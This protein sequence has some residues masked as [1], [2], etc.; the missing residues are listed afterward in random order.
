MTSTSNTVSSWSAW[1]ENRK[2]CFHGLMLSIVKSFSIP[3]KYCVLFLERFTFCKKY[4]HNWA[5][6]MDRNFIEQYSIVQ[7][8]S[9][10]VPYPSSLFKKKNKFSNFN[11]LNC[12]N[13]DKKYKSRFETMKILSEIKSLTKI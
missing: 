4:S 10:R 3:N 12:R 8:T 1:N 11:F 13:S 2:M 7:F 9:W 5:I 6:H